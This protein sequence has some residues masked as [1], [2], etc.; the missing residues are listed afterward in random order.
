LHR[1]PGAGIAALP[2]ECAP[3][4]LCLAKE[5]PPRPVEKKTLFAANSA[6]CASLLVYGSCWL[7][8]PTESGH[9]LLAAL[10]NVP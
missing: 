4:F 6:L 7:E 2:Q 8:V 5:K 9:L 10:D 3:A 1:K